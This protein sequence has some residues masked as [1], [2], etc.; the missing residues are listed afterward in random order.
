M[1]YLTMNQRKK[2]RNHSHED[3]DNTDDL[4]YI[5]KFT[6]PRAKVKQPAVVL[7]KHR[8]ARSFATLLSGIPQTSVSPDI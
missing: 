5:A 1:F 2:T 4:Q 6:R 8:H 3:H 7:F